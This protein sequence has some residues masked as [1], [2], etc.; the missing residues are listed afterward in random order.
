LVGRIGSGQ[1]CCWP[2][3]ADPLGGI[4]QH[5]EI[6]IVVAECGVALAG[7]AGLISVFGSSKRMLDFT[8]LLGMVKNSLTAAAFALLP[9]APFSLGVPDSLVWRGSAIVF[10]LVHTSVVIHA[11]VKLAELRR[12]AAA[13]VGRAAYFTYPAGVV[14]ILFLLGACLSSEYQLASGL[15][16]CALLTVLAISGV[17]FLSL[18]GS[19]IKANIRASLE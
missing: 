15:Y 16:I 2:L 13:T 3:N 4:L 9:F 19:F 10:F 11:W 8:R 14:S 6:L 5:S 12:T 7:F 1:H 18:F 17:L